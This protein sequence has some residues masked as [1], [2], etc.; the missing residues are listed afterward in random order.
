VADIR[1]VTGEQLPFVERPA[2]GDPVIRDPGIVSLSPFPG[3]IYPPTW[4]GRYPHLMPIDVKIWDRFMDRYA[5]EFVG[6]QYDVTV[7]EGALPL[8]GM[9]AQDRFILWSLTVKRVDCLG[10]RR[11]SVTLFEV[12]PRLGMAAIGQMTSYAVLWQKQYGLP[13]AMRVAT[14]CEQSERDLAFVCQRLGFQVV[15]V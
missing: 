6:L 14:V 1:V 13:P 10:I 12:K 3:P 11:D 4:R 2:A 15:V 5:G 9:S 8:P 7:G